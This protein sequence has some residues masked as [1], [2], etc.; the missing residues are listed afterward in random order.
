MA[1][2]DRKELTRTHQTH[3]WYPGHPKHAEGIRSANIIIGIHRIKYARD[4]G[5]HQCARGTFLTHR[6]IMSWINGT[7]QRL[8]RFGRTRATYEGGLGLVVW[9]HVAGNALSANVN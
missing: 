9:N 8:H 1:R 6:V 7:G 2:A 3:L 5:T 4:G